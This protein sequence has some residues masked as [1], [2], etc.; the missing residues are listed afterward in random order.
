MKTIRIFG[1]Y[2]GR[3]WWKEFV[4]YGNRNTKICD[5]CKLK[6]KCFTELERID[7]SAKE[8]P[9]PVYSVY[10]L[11]TERLIEYIVPAVKIKIVKDGWK[12]KAQ[13]DFKHPIKGY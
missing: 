4:C 9:F 2:Q 12:T 1:M 5:E 6:F 10:E 13:T 8:L 3:E 11:D 7:V